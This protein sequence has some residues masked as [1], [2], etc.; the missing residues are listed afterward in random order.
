M[1]KNCHNLKWIYG[2]NNINLSNIENMSYLF[3]EC[4]SLEYLKFENSNTNNLKF[5]NHMFYNCKNLK[6]LLFPKKHIFVKKENIDFTSE[7]INKKIINNGDFYYI[8]TQKEISVTANNNIYNKIKIEENNKLIKYDKITF[9][10]NG[11]L[12]LTLKEKNV[13]IYDFYSENKNTKEYENCEKIISTF[14]FDVINVNGFNTSLVID[15]SYMFFGCQKLKS[16]NIGF[17]KSNFCKNIEGMFQ[18]CNNLEYINLFSFTTEKINNY[19][20]IFLNS[21]KLK[22]LI[23][24]EKIGIFSKI[25]KFKLLKDNKELFII[26]SK[27]NLKTIDVIFYGYFHFLKTHNI[28]KYNYIMDNFIK[29]IYTEKKKEYYLNSNDIYEKNYSYY[30]DHYIDY[31]KNDF[32]IIDDDYKD[33][34]NINS[35]D[36]IKNINEINLNDWFNGINFYQEYYYHG[37]SGFI[38]KGYDKNKN[39]FAFKFIPENKSKY[40][41]KNEKNYQIL[42]MYIKNDIISNK[43][44]YPAKNHFKIFL[45]TNEIIYCFISKFFK[46]GTLTDFFTLNNNK[47]NLLNILYIAGELTNMLFD[48]EKIGM[49][50]GDFNPNNIMIDENYNFKII[51]FSVTKFL[52]TLKKNKDNVELIFNNDK[53]S[54]KVFQFGTLYFCSPEQI[55]G[56]SINIEYFNKID[57]FGLGIILYKLFFK[58]YP[59]NFSGLNYEEFSDVA[60]FYEKRLN[61]INNNFIFNEFDINNINKLI[62]KNNINEEYIYKEFIVFLTSCLNKNIKY[63]ANASDLLKTNFYKIYSK[64]KEI[65]FNLFKNLFIN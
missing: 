19:H 37:F 27:K 26:L 11:I 36:E 51:D 52:K 25:F 29:Y 28:N 40:F 10:K 57:I 55:N 14:F 30:F 3:Y 45:N 7:N 42:N 5:C 17:F 9:Y 56:N 21:N 22:E 61:Q 50:H 13:K 43:Y 12:K 49:C 33:E 46:N 54:F 6:K 64:N 47:I 44:I 8:F 65:L 1:F 58:N 23:I 60:E 24:N 41:I 4:S 38:L 34:N 15:M 59:Y 35:L 18:N 16:I 63:R 39:E 2:F 32:E 31:F 20:N 48:F 53:S 62:N